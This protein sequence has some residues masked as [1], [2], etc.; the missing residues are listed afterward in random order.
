ME[1]LDTFTFSPDVTRE[2]FHEPLTDKA[3]K[4]F[5]EA[6]SRGRGVSGMEK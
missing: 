2:L 1:G 6:A 4:E 5:E 3:A